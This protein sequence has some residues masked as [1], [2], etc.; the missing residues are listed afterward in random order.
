MNLARLPTPA[1]RSGAGLRAL[2][3]AEQ[4][5]AAYPGSPPLAHGQAVPTAFGEELPGGEAV[6]GGVVEQ[7]PVGRARQRG[8]GDLLEEEPPAGSQDPAISARA[9]RQSSTWWMI[10]NSNTA[11]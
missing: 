11:S 1:Q 5:V 10:P 6:F 2:R 9:A 3:D 8:G 4:V 7:Q